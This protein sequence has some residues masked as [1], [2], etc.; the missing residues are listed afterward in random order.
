MDFTL[1]P[2]QLYFLIVA[3]WVNRRAVRH[4]ILHFPARVLAIVSCDAL[5]FKEFPVGCIGPAIFGLNRITPEPSQN[6]VIWSAQESLDQHTRRLR[7][8]AIL[9]L[10]W[11]S[12]QT[13]EKSSP[14]RH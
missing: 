8:P 10:A 9:A 3:G 2:W 6:L 11:A 12:A 5:R 1:H 13:G 7:K 4:N 14:S